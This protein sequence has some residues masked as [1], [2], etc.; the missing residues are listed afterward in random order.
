MKLDTLMFLLCPVLYHMVLHA[1]SHSFVL[2]KFQTVTE[3][4]VSICSAT[5]CCF[6]SWSV[7]SGVFHVCLSTL[8]GPVAGGCSV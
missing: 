8:V 7:H 5:C 4:C 3:V 2:I 6:P 1:I